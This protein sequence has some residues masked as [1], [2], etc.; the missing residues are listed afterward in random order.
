MTTGCTNPKAINYDPASDQ[1]DGSCIYLHHVGGVC[2][3]FEDY[4]GDNLDDQSFTVS[5]SVE[6][7][8]WV[9]YHDYIPDF[10]LSTRQQLYSLKNNLIWKHNAGPR[11]KFYKPTKDSFYVDIV[12]TFPEDVLL[13]SVQWMTQVVDS[14][15]TT[16]Q[17]KTFTHITVWNDFQCTGRLPISHY[18]PLQPEGI[19]KGLSQFSFNELRDIVSSNGTLVMK[20]ILDGLI[21]EDSSLDPDLPWYEKPYMHNKYFVIRLEFDNTEDKVV[22]LHSVDVSVDQHTR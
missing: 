1:D 3:A 19:K 15:N 21:P 14:L 10:Y 11:G 16:H 6:G 2:Y 7:N 13:N 22:S 5:Y 12:F 9:F 4:T 20:S 8:A 17:F 18:L